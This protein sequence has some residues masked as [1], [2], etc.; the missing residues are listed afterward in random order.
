MYQIGPELKHI[1]VKF[2]LETG[3]WHNEIFQHWWN[4]GIS[5]DIAVDVDLSDMERSHTDP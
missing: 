4:I 1:F 5:G 2:R 3:H